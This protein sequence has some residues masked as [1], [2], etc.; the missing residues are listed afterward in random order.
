MEKNIRIWYYALTLLS[1][2]IVLSSGCKKDEEEDDNRTFT[3]GE[4]YG[5][6]IIFFVENIGISAGKHGLIAATS[7]QSNAPW[8]C[9]G[10]YIIGTSNSVGTGQANTS[11]IVNNCSTAGIAARICD[12]LEL[13]GFSDW[14]LPSKDELNLMYNNLHLQG[15]GNFQ[16]NAPY[17][18]SSQFN[19]VNAF[20]GSF[21]DGTGHFVTKSSAIYVR[22]IRAF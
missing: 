10:T 8:G 5:G 17:W 3:V 18:S 22:A 4:S 12:Q 2:L 20:A 11:A 1:V 13:N 16:T 6:G 7:N 15:L 14:F 9:E 21:G 19:E